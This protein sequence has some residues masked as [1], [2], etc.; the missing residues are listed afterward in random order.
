MIRKR[1]WG[2]VGLAVFGLVLPLAI[3]HATG[4]THRGD[5][6]PG[7]QCA[8]AVVRV[9]RYHTPGGRRP[10][11]EVLQHRLDSEPGGVQVDGWE[12]QGPAADGC[13][14][15]FR[16]HARNQVVYLEWHL[17][18]RTSAVRVEKIEQTGEW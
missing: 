10:L 4:G 7:G 11:A 18:S 13:R 3:G 2:G 14:V 17:N 9:Q 12:N 5:A 1:A 15:A 8:D 6:A 16:Y